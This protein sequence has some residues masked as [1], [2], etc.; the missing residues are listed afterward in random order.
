MP[1]LTATWVSDQFNWTTSEA[2]AHEIVMTIGFLGKLTNRAVHQ[3]VN[4]RISE[5]IIH[6][7]H[8]EKKIWWLDIDRL[9]AAFPELKLNKSWHGKIR[10]D[11]EVEE[12]IGNL[13]T[14]NF[15]NAVFS[16]STDEIQL[17][18]GRKIFLSHKSEDKKV[19][20]R[21]QRALEAIGYEV[22]LDEKNLQ[23]GDPLER[24]ILNGFNESCAAV[25]F[26]TENF[27]DEKYLKT[28]IDYAI[29]QTREKENYFKIITLAFKTGKEKVAIPELLQS[30]VWKK[31][32]TELDA[33]IEIMKALPLVPRQF[34]FKG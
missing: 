11:A 29:A 3:K 15:T 26:I 6:W 20:R 27:K 25:F 8:H 12:G 18:Q 31:P 10:L 2:P 17:A 19:V 9:R 23:A 34:D 13:A 1:S 21:F 30:Y 14:H 16:I 7:L 22:W 4:K 5:G 32:A 28:E 33:L 24:G